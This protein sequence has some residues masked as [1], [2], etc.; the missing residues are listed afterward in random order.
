MT[1]YYVDS[2][3][4][5]DGNNGLTATSAFQSFQQLESV[6]KDGDVVNLARGSTWH[7]ALNISQSNILVQGYGTG[8][9]PLINGDN[10]ARN[11]IWIS[12]QN[13]TI[14]HIDGVSGTEGVCIQGIGASASVIGGT[15]DKCGVGIGVGGGGTLGLGVNG[16]GLGPQEWG[17]LILADGVTCTNSVNGPAA[18]DGIQIG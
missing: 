3:A 5:S 4:G 1:V 12:G 18:G 17:Q 15:Y 13:V 10:Y 8:A 6:L 7:E 11:C 2:A 16:H 9:D 14:D